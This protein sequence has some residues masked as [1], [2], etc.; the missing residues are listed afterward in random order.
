MWRCCARMLLREEMMLC[1]ATTQEGMLL[2]EGVTLRE[3]V[4][5]HEGRT[6]YDVTLVC[7]GVTPRRGTVLRERTMLRTN[8]TEAQHVAYEK[9]LQRPVKTFCMLLNY[10]PRA[11]RAF[12]AEHEQSPK[13][14]EPSR[15]EPSIKFK[16]HCHLC[17]WVEV[18]LGLISGINRV[19]SRYQSP[20]SIKNASRFICRPAFT[21]VSIASA[22]KP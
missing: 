3:G 2:S 1:K 21:A 5:L 18:S 14:L 9:R 8:E 13:L 16:A 11:P 17:L 10:K 19:R 15:A 7:Q 20:P 4:T 6:L 12:R 22:I